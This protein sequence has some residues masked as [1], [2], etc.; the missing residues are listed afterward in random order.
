MWYHKVLLSLNKHQILILPIF[1][2]DKKCMSLR[3]RHLRLCGMVVGFQVTYGLVLSI[4]EKS[5]V[6]IPERSVFQRNSL[7]LVI[8]WFIAIKPYSLHMEVKK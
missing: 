3:S 1:N 4:I 6:P 8:I 5:I 2:S 7:L